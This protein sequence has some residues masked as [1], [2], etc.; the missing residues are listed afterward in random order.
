MGNSLR[1]EGR[2]L[3]VDGVRELFADLNSGVRKQVRSSLIALGKEGAQVARARSP[4]GESGGLRASIQTFLVESAGSVGVNVKAV[5]PEVPYGY[6]LEFGVVSHGRKNNK[7][8]KGGKRA[9][10]AAREALMAA[11][12]WRISPRP[13]F[14]S[15]R[16]MMLG[17]LRDTVNDA[18]QDAIGSA[19]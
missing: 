1:F 10:K 4:R 19:T 16:A 2:V 12:K 18:I 11:G 7:R 3:G 14:G 15:A 5:Q 8:G 17:R 9:R 13:W 6:F